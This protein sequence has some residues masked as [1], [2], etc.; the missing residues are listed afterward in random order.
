M[1][2]ANFPSDT[3]NNNCNNL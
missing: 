2:A 3:K 1:A